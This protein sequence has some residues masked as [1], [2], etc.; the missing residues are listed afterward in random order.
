MLRKLGPLVLFTLACACGKDS[1]LAPSADASPAAAEAGVVPSVAVLTRN[2]YVGADVD[3]VIAA[4]VS[5]SPEDDIP[6]LTLAIQTL[7]HTDFTTRAGAIADEIARHR[8]HAVGLQEVS[9]IHIDLTPLNLPIA[10]NL[11]FLPVLQQALAARGLHYRVAATIKNIEAAPLPGVSLVDFDA[12]LVDADRVQVT[13]HSSHTYSLNIGQVAPGVVL[14]RGWVSVLATV[15][16]R[17]YQ[18][19]STHLESGNAAGLDQLRAVQASELAAAL[20]TGTPTILMGDLNDQPGSPMYQ[21]LLGAGYTDLWTAL[22]PG[23][24]GFTC[25]HATDLSNQVAAFT[26]RIDYILA[27]GLR[28]DGKPPQGSVAILGDQPSDR[29]MGPEGLIWPSDHAGLA[30]D[31]LQSMSP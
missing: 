6:A 24:K 21:A 4:L 8:P 12:L 7:Q 27:R 9:E 15:D 28:S 25:C 3:A 18:F 13:D 19:A 29:V 17:P 2:L 20:G 22:R 16:G 23:V 26:Q 14:K 10:L 5:P 1:P 30:A 31:L 11:D